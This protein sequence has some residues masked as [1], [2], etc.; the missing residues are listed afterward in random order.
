MTIRTSE[1]IRKE[2]EDEGHS[3]SVCHDGAA[4]LLPAL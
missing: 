4:G 3:V 1:Y 2:L